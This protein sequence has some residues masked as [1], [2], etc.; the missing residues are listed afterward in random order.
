MCCTCSWRE[1]EASQD[2]FFYDNCWIVALCEKNNSREGK[3]GSSD[4]NGK[5]RELSVWNKGKGDSK[6]RNPIIDADLISFSFVA[7]ILTASGSYARART[8]CRTA[9]VQSGIVLCCLCVHLTGCCD[10]F[11]LHSELDCFRFKLVCP[12]NR[13]TSIHIQF[14][15]IAA[16]KTIRAHDNSFKTW[17]A[18]ISPL[19]LFSPTFWCCHFNLV[20]R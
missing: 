17:T 1:T 11:A 4:L 20:Y 19:R 18:T 15:F 6:S 12:S 8:V 16:R 9:A 2:D 13:F 14:K 3:N 7:C 10:Y 5:R